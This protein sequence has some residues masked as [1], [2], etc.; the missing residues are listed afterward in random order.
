MN[1]QVFLKTFWMV[2]AIIVV[3]ILFVKIES[4]KEDSFDVEDTARD[5]G[6]IV[7]RMLSLEEK[8]IEVNYILPEGYD[9]VLRENIV[10]VDFKNDQGSFEIFGDFSLIT[11][12]ITD[13]VLIK[14]EVLIIN[15]D[16]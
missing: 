3:G 13:E 7:N 2:M 11:F 8:E 12:E 16:G 6:L 9:I 5:I 15:K 14:K 10:F 1:T 4:F